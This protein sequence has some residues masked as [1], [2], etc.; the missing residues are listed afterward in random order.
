MAKIVG[1]I[2][3]TKVNKIKK[4]K[5]KTK[6]EASPKKKNPTS[7]GHMHP[8]RIFKDPG[9]LEKAFQEYKEF[10]HTIECE[11][12]KKFQYVG[13]EGHRVE[14]KLK[15]PL[16]IEGFENFCYNKYGCVNQYMDNKGKYFNEFVTICSRIK[17]EIRQDQIT[18]GLLGFYNPSITQRL[19][20]LVD[21]VKNTNEVT[22]SI[23]KT[24][25]TKDKA[26]NIVSKFSKDI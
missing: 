13:K 1:K 24:T 12:W 21:N 11:K 19:N 25:L 6:I 17:S 16:T 7:S 4:N 10:V 15:V 8:T 14:D 9:E 23:D 26:K 2:I 22:V 18:G 5:L 20:S 3:K